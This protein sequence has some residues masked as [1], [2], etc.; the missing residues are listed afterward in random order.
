MSLLQIL[1]V[2]TLLCLPF[3]LHFTL[4]T[5]LNL[6]KLLFSVLCNYFL[7]VSILILDSLLL[8]L[9]F[10]LLSIV[11]LRQGLFQLLFGLLL[12]IIELFSLLANAITNVLFNLALALTDFLLTLALGL[13]FGVFELVIVTGYVGSLTLTIAAQSYLGIIFKTILCFLEVI[14]LLVSKLL[15]LASM[16]SLEV[17]F[18]IFDLIT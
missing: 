5:L 3:V 9:D 11:L 17:H 15:Q 7:S 6:T 8:R 2:F 16:L 4:N 18:L 14:F 12:L 1:L 10:P 13:I